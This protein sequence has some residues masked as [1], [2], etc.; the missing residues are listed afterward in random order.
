MSWGL[1]DMAP[2]SNDMFLDKLKR[3]EARPHGG[4]FCMGIGALEALKKNW[5]P[6]GEAAVALGARSSIRWRARAR[7]LCAKK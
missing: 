5:T 4:G 1:P 6:M 2:K 3:K 7:T